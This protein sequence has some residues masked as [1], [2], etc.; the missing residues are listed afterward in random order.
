MSKGLSREVDINLGD[1]VMQVKSGNARGLTGQLQAT[2]AT[3]D[4]TA[5]GYA[6]D[7]PNAAWE[8]AARQG[9]PIARTPDELVAMVKE[10]GR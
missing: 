5:I 3:T 4:R 6:P 2:T 8:A 1:L 10:L 7:I 9:I